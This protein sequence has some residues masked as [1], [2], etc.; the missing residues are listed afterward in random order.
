[1]QAIIA[2]QGDKDFDH[3][4]P[5]LGALTFEVSAPGDGVVAGSTTC[6]SPALRA[7]P[8]H[9]KCRAGVDL[10]CKLGDTVTTGQALTACMPGFRPTGICIARPAPRPVATVSVRPTMCRMFVEF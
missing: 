5:Q 10:L 6:R 9:P 8:V 2:A 1:M 4:D 3:N 7:W